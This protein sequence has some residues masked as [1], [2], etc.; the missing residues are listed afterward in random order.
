M[1]VYMRMQS[2]LQPSEH[3]NPYRTCLYFECVSFQCHGLETF[4]GI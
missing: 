3:I 4:G 2:I 1:Q